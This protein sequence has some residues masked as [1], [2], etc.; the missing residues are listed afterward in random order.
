MPKKKRGTHVANS[1]F[2]EFLEAYAGMPESERL[3]V[4]QQLAK[5][6]PLSKDAMRGKLDEYAERYGQSLDDLL[7]DFIRSGELNEREV[8]EAIGMLGIIDRFLERPSKW[9]QSQQ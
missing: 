7:I 1:D 9:S 2:K 4:A 8:T 5:D 3:L 6:E